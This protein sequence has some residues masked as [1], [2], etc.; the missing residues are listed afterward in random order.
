MSKIICNLR[1][2]DAKQT[3]V[4]R[5]TNNILNFFPQNI[6]EEIAPSPFF[7]HGIKG[8]FWEQA[9]L[10]LLAKKNDVLWSPSNT[11]PLSL[12][13]QIVTIHDMVA[14]DNKEWV[15]SSFGKMYR[16]MQPKLA[17]KVLHIIAVSNFT[18]ERIIQNLKIS[19]EKI[20][21]IH[22]GVED[23]FFQPPTDNFLNIPFK[24]YILTLGA[25]EPRKNLKGLLDAWIKIKDKIDTDTGL[26]VVGT[27]GSAKV[28]GNYVIEK[29]IERVFF[30]G[31]I[32][33]KYLVSLY[34][35]A[36]FFVYLSFYEG[37][38]F[39]PLEAM[40]A[41]CPV[42]ASNKTAM[43][44]VIG[45]AGLF[46]DPYSLNEIQTGILKYYNNEN[47]R[48]INKAKGRNKALE[49]NWKDAS[50]KTLKVFKNLS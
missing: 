35:N 12:K 28:F 37:F 40:A 41:N 50:A 30:T 5:Y 26:V 32:D 48:A 23:K 20:T 42:M 14:F 13:N 33:E 19:E 15:T 34:S 24:K 22:H 9:V 17:K 29:N 7:S 16:W 2:L 43:P 46:V 3:G 8:H 49:F 6:Y 47:L 39:P 45:S 1:S 27:Q 11:G 21:V 25:I 31:Y 44:E 18:K 36:M 38:G 4:Q 10:P